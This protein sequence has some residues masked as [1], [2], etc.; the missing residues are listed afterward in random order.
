MTTPPLLSEVSIPHRK[1]CLEKHSFIHA[2]TSFSD[3]LDGTLLPLNNSPSS[4]RAWS[5]KYV[6]GDKACVVDVDG[7]RDSTTYRTAPHG[8]LAD[9][10]DC[11]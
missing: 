8:S 7:S 10:M 5:S 1:P 6:A 4:P 9:T 3:T 2:R 11:A